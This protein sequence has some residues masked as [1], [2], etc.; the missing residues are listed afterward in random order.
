MAAEVQ[1]VACP[2]CDIP[3]QRCI[4]EGC[5]RV[6]AATTSVDEY[7]RC[8]AWTVNDVVGGKQTGDC[9]EVERR[10]SA[11]GGYRKVN[12]CAL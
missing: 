11:A 1:S 7:F 4:V 8:R 9:E 10:I 6:F 3:Q 5:L 12:Y 2:H